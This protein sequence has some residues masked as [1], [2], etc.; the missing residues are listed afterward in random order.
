MMK[1]NDI[2]ELLKEK[3]KN[4]DSNK[5]SF[6]VNIGS[7]KSQAIKRRKQK[8]IKI[9]F[10]TSA[11]ACLILLSALYILNIRTKIDIQP[12]IKVENTIVD[13]IIYNKIESKVEEV[14]ESILIGRVKSINNLGI[15]NGKPTTEIEISIE[16]IIQR[17]DA[18]I[19]YGDTLIK[20]IYNG[21]IYKAGELPDEVRDAIKQNN[22]NYDEYIKVISEEKYNDIPFPEEGKQYIMTIYE[23]KNQFYIAPYAEKPLVEYDI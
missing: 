2:D 3:A 21:C 23:K 4:I 8:I 9:S 5:Y 12:E 15:K 22:Y 1:D 19:N 7:I 13:T 17:G 18:L 20:V 11:C 14:K 10:I 16:S 6:K